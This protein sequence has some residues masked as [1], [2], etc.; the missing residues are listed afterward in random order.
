MCRLVG[1]RRWP[2]GALARLVS[3]GLLVAVALVAVASGGAPARAAM[4]A[5][6]ADDAAQLRDL[7]QRLLAGPPG[8]R[9]DSATP[10][11]VELLTGQLPASPALDLPTPAGAR[12]VGSAVRR[13]DGKVNGVDVVL[14]V[15]GKTGDVFAFYR[16]G[17]T[18]R[19]WTLS[20]RGAPASGF[21][22][23]TPYYT[24][25]FCRAPGAG[26]LQLNIGPRANGPNDVR[27]HFDSFT[28][29]PC[30]SGDGASAARPAGEARLPALAAPLGATILVQSSSGNATR[31]SSSATATTAAG[32]ADLEAGY[33][34]QLQAAGWTRAAGRV[35]GPLA[36]SSWAVA[37][38]GGWQGYFYALRTGDQRYDLFVQVE[39]PAAQPAGTPA[40]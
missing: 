1:S 8:T 6:S 7:A 11:T 3:A 31:W 40:P 13:L 12:L 10:M 26:W 21:L 28:I 35:D 14:D 20:T 32:L 24:G 19:G 29:G 27:L 38:P 4:P 30:A 22:A 25:T 2:V 15:P 33:A 34:R 17:L 9:A 39:A 37:G 5:A 16:D 23:S 18:G 36:W